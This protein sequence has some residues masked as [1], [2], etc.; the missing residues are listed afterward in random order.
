MNDHIKFTRQL[1]NLPYMSGGDG[2]AIFDARAKIEQLNDRISKS[3]MK[4]F[5]TKNTQGTGRKCSRISDGDDVGTGASAGSAGGADHA[6]LR[7]HGYEV[8]PE[9]IVDASGVVFEPLFKVW[10]PFSTC[11]TP[12]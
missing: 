6:A 1:Y 12:Y 5:H 3:A 8:E 4:S 11:C 10:Q 7:A 9:D 2:N